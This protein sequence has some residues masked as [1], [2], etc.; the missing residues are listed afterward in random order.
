MKIGEKLHFR[1]SGYAWH[2]KEITGEDYLKIILRP[3]KSELFKKDMGRACHRK[4]TEMIYDRKRVLF[5]DWIDAANT[6]HPEVISFRMMDGEIEENQS[7]T[8]V[9]QKNE[10]LFENI[11]QWNRK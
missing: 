3:G 8:V 5:E 7:N 11:F 2:T 10:V 4:Y 1:K 6:Q 9:I